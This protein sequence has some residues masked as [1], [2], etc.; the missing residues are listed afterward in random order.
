MP[1][2]GMWGSNIS[3]GLFP[4]SQFQKTTGVNFVSKEKFTNSDTD[5]VNPGDVPSIY[6]ECVFTLT[7]RVPTLDLMV[8]PVTLNYFWT[9]DPGTC[10]HIE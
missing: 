3:K 9:V 6:P 10:G 8:D 4:L 1:N 5:P 7:T 2:V